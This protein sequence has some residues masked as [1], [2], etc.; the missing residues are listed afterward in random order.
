MKLTVLYPVDFTRQIH[1]Q[2]MATEGFLAAVR[3]RHTDVPEIKVRVSQRK[4]TRRRAHDRDTVVRWTRR[5]TKSGTRHELLFVPQ[6][7]FLDGQYVAGEIL[8]QVAFALLY[9]R[10]LQDFLVNNAHG[11]QFKAVAEELGLAVAEP[12]YDVPDYGCTFPCRLWDHYADE[13]T[14]LRECP[15][16]ASELPR[17]VSKRINTVMGALN[18]AIRRYAKPFTPR[19]GP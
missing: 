19:L 1:A 8:H 13:M 2:R 18:A 14:V 12:C 11:P 5:I 15:S 3:R 17:I 16:A 9:E 4:T 7:S 6:S 10:G